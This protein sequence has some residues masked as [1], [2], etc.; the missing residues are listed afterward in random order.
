V[1]ASIPGVGEAQ[2]KKGPLVQVEKVSKLYP[3]HA[4]LLGKPRFLHAVDGVSFYIRRGETLGLVGESG[5]GKSTLGRV[6]IR[7]L[8]P[9]L[10]R[11]VFDGA[12]ITAKTA[13][14]LRP[15]R[16]RMQIVF[17]DP[18]SS[19]NPRMTLREIV[20]E[21]I[22]VHRLAKGRREA[23]EKILAVLARVGLGADMLGR[24]PHE[25]SGGQRQRVGIARALAVGP[26]FIVCDEPV[27]AL[28]V[29]VQAQVLNLLEALQ[30]DL[31]L[32][33]LFISHDLRVIEYTSHRTAVMYLGR[34][35]EMGP[36]ADV[37][38]KR[39][40]PYTRAL[41]GAVPSL[42]SEGKKRLV[43]QGEPPSAIDPP[44]GC[45]FHPRCPRAEQGRCDVEAPQ[46]QELVPGSHHRVACW[47]PETD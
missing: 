42:D 8:E 5:C 27:S 36:T 2:G 26:E 25:L 24:Y 7:L 9:T 46:L 10:G 38:E 35:V 4:G 29:S 41:F 45:A 43:L 21:G 40:H 15:L 3:V 16:R 37:A 13:D 17:Q 19:L 33:L 20:G 32:S 44:T 39:H 18:Y 11:V 47:H 34:I 30:D 22:A 14:E 31:G 12:D 28:D 23:E 1:T 6:V